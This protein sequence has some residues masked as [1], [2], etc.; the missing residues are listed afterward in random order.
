MRTVRITAALVLMCIA[1][2][3]SGCTH[4][5]YLA[6]EPILVNF[7]MKE[8]KIEDYGFLGAD[9]KAAML[10]VYHAGVLVLQI[11]TNVDTTCIDGKCLNSKDFI[12][13]FICANLPSDALVYILNA[14]PIPTLTKMSNGFGFEQFDEACNFKYS[15]QDRSIKAQTPNFLLS[16]GGIH[17]AD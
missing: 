11:E 16:L 8:Y 3:F 14:K 1:L 12:K 7:S 2:I 4:K 9:D 6:N 13:D 10:N 5:S 17:D 15:V